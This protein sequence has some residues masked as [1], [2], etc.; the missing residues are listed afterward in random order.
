MSIAGGLPNAIHRG[1]AAGCGKLDV[2]GDRVYTMG[3]KGRSSYLFALSRANG[4]LLWSA[5]VGEPGGYGV[6]S[7]IVRKALAGA[8]A[9][10]STGEC[11]P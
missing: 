7:E 9:P 6:P 5:K 10:V 4:K 3:D 2:A 1:T 8:R 11:A